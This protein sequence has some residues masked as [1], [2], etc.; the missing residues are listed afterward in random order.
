MTGY[1]S[2]HPIDLAFFDELI[3]P[4][5]AGRKVNPEAFLQRAA[6]QRC[7]G[8][9]A[10]GFAVAVEQLA[11]SFEAPKPDP[12]ASPWKRL[13]ANL[14]RIDYRP[15]EMARLAARGFDPDLHLDG[16][17]FFIVEG[18]AEKVATAVDAYAAAESEPA[19]EKIARHQVALLHAEMAQ[20]VAPA[21]IPDLGSDLGYR[22]DLLGLLQKIFELARAARE[23]KPW[24][25]G[26]APPLPATEV[27][28]HELPW[29][30][31][32]M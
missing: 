5:V 20:E 25:D 3:A 19:V 2:F 14:E 7:N 15:D 32:S 17:P 22:G 8:W 24:G 28:A 4:L 11:A 6:I 23:G 26:D 21:E 16:R 27:L 12:T 10:R 13:R 31:L 9:V 1:V 18:S 29:R 30:A